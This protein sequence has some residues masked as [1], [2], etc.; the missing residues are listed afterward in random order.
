MLLWLAHLAITLEDPGSVFHS[1]L[2]TFFN[3]RNWLL[4]GNKKGSRN[5]RSKLDPFQFQTEDGL[6][7]ASGPIHSP[8]RYIYSPIYQFFMSGSQYNEK[9]EKLDIKSLQK[10][11]LAYELTWL[12]Q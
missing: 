7:Y 6:R 5:A 3:F 4:F 12:H 8:I 1:D 11:S 10:N 9:N 2:D